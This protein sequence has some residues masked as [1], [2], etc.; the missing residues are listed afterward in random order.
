MKFLKTYW[1]AFALVIGAVLIYWFMF[2]ED[3][4]VVKKKDTTVCK[5]HVGQAAF[6]A[7]V[8]AV[9]TQMDGD[10]TWRASIVA[11]KTATQTETEAIEKAADDF[12]RINEGWCP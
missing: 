1:W 10:A 8:L 5:S 12:V 4:V 3:A 11:K 7:R 6:D 2:R 9:A